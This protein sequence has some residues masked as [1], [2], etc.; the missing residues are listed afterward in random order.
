MSRHVTSHELIAD[1]RGFFEEVVSEALDRKKIKIQPVVSNYLVDLLKRYLITENLFD[2]EDGSGRK[3]RSTLAEMF[4]KSSHLSP[5]QRVE[6]LKR[7]GDTSLYI[8]GFFAPSLQRKVVD[9][10]YYV[11]MGMSA[12]GTLAEMVREDTFAAVYSEMERKFTEF[13]DAFSFISLQTM[14]RQPADLM[15]LFS[16]YLETGSEWAHQEILKQ[17]VVPPS[18]PKA[19]GENG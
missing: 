7:L 3:R 11:D 13:V 6:T 18:F 17:G 14:S 19:S 16:L 8:S 12:Y 1:S 4:L 9:V 10:S 5:A 2:S 15:T